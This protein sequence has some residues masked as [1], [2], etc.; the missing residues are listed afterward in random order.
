MDTR[1][2]A[3]RLKQMGILDIIA[4]VI[5]AGMGVLFWS[6]GLTARV[7]GE[8]T[9]Q[10]AQALII[11]GVLLVPLGV[12]AILYV[13]RRTA[14][15]AMA[16]SIYACAVAVCSVAYTVFT[17]INQGGAFAFVGLFGFVASIPTLILI[18]R[19]R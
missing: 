7:G 1:S 11:M 10:L 3:T 15:I 5:L 12:L 14:A 16:A 4:A 18:R 9:I 8:S 19:L 13:S 17:R 2:A 6:T